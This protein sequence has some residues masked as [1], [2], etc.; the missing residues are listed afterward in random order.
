MSRRDPPDPDL[1]AQIS[2]LIDGE[3]DAETA[4]RLR[5]D[6]AVAAR[7]AEFERGDALVAQIFAEELTEPT[8]TP[9]RDMLAQSPP[10]PAPPAAVRRRS[11]RQAA[12]LALAAG[13]GAAATFGALTWSPRPEVPGWIAQIAGYHR[14]YSAESARL[15]EIPATQPEVIR[16][17]LGGR[18]GRFEI[19]DFSRAGLEF[20]GA[21][22]L[23]AVG[24]PVAQLVYT[25]AAGDVV[26]LCITP[27]PG[28][29]D[30]APQRRRVDEFA[31]IDWR[32][33]GQAFIL[34]GPSAGPDLAPLA[35]AAR[36][37]RA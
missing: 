15:V 16:D 31:T 1:D 26:A 6:P 5:A 4:E 21:R 37:G 25:N 28:T 19:P 32:E 7:I 33:D 2:A 14:V 9:L 29:A 24:K 10:A 22:L 17:W 23:A 3:L 12:A 13:L 34:I 30:A 27:R 8:T 11:R 35:D 20:R 18:V 36:G